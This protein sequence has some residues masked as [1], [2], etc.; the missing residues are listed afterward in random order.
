MPFKRLSYLVINLP[1]GFGYER[2]CTFK[3]SLG[4]HYASTEVGRD[5]CTY[6]HLCLVRRRVETSTPHDTNTRVK[7]TTIT[8]L[9]LSERLAIANIT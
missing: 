8:I 6:I 1:F 4:G 2:K 5:E 7:M 3:L 9:S